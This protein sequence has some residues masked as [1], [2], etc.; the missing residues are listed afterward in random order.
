[1]SDF[2]FGNVSDPVIEPPKGKRDKVYIFCGRGAGVP[3]LPRRI[4][5]QAAKEQG[6]YRL[7]QAAIKNGNYRKE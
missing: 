2:E 5:E 7:L 3:G 6:K 4:S 1:M